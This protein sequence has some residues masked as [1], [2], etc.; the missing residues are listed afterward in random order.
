MQIIKKV[1]FGL[2]Y[3]PQQQEI[4]DFWAEH[5]LEFPR[6]YQLALIMLAIAPMS[7]RSERNF[8]ISNALLSK[9]ELQCVQNVLIVYCAHRYYF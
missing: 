7:S 2:I 4:L 6:L 8:S 3:D 1:Q 5:K 9:K